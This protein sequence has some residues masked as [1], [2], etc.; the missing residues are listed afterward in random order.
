MAYQN[1]AERAVSRASTFVLLLTG[2]FGAERQL[3][4]MPRLLGRVQ[5][6]FVPRCNSGF[7]GHQSRSHNTL[8]IEALIWNFIASAVIA[9]I[10]AFAAAFLATRRTKNEARW[11]ASYDAYT[12]IL[13]SVEDIRFW[14][15]ETYASNLLLPSASAEQLNAA[16]GRY[17]EARRIL[18]SFAHV[19][20]LVISEQCRRELDELISDLSREDF[21]FHEDGTDE[22][23]FS[24]E[25]AEHCEKVRTLIESHLP[26][27]VASAKKDL[28]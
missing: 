4:R 12:R 28:R 18:S 8:L 27:I 19:G 10:A 22:E 9:I 17:E 13:S 1:T 21:R 20:A 2:P 5:G 3:H 15:D 25:L 7:Q 11:R 16:E 23:N 14:A 6:C 24:R 26:Q